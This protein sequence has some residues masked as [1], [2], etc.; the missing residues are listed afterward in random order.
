MMAHHVHATKNILVHRGVNAIGGVG[1]SVEME[2]V[3]QATIWT[4]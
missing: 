1:L 3:I 2:H 4:F